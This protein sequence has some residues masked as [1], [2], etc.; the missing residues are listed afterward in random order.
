MSQ[1]RLRHLRLN[2]VFDN[3]V[4][5]LLPVHCL[6]EISQVLLPEGQQKPCWQ[7]CCCEAGLMLPFKK[8]L[9]E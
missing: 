2:D 3:P 5:D 7:G 8:G 4:H 1:G 6:L 9:T